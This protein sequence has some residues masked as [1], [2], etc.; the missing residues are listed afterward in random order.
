M[1][2]LHPDRCVFMHLQIQMSPSAGAT[3]SPCTYCDPISILNGWFEDT[4]LLFDAS[5]LYAWKALADPCLFPS[6]GKLCQALN[7][8]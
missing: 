1:W 6:P 8:H 2:V 5:S 4:D 3:V 7:S